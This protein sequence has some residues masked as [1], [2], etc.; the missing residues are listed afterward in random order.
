MS[1]FRTWDQLSKLEQLQCIY[2]DTYK[3]HYGFRP[4]PSTEHCNDEK[5]LESEL[6]YLYNSNDPQSHKEN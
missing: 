4:R 5:W 6:E 1:K 2:S 3:E